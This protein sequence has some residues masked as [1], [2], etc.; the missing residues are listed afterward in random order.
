MELAIGA[1]D[2]S[3]CGDVKHCTAILD[4]FG[5]QFFTPQVPLEYFDAILLQLRI[6]TA[7]ERANLETQFE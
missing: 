4:S 3:E 5:H 7:L 6:R 1:R 2:C